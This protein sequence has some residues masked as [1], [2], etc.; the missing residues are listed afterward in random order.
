[1]T[2]AEK[3]RETLKDFERPVINGLYLGSEKE[4]FVFIFSVIPAMN[5]DD[6]PNM[7]RYLTQLHYFCPH[8]VDCTKL[9]QAVKEK[10]FDAG[11]TWPDEVDA[12]DE[13]SRHYVF[14]C[15]IEGRMDGTV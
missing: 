8:D 11:W 3:I 1:M 2:A 7:E 6:R 15:E 14:E 4:Y 5:A 9:R 12:T 13:T 10:L